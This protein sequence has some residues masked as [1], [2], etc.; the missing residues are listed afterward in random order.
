MPGVAPN[1]REEFVAQSCS[2]TCEYTD[3]GQLCR[4]LLSRIS[5]QEQLLSDPVLQ[6]KDAS[7]DVFSL[8]SILATMFTR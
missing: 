5:V 3:S 4:L 1:F 8:Y 7:E 2:L 6:W